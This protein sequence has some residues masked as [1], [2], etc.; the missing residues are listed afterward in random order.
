MR[1]STHFMLFLDTSEE[2]YG[3]YVVNQKQNPRH[4]FSSHSGCHTHQGPSAAQE[5]TTI[6]VGGSQNHEDF[7]KEQTK[8]VIK[9]EDNSH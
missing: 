3:S 7:Q 5:A 2:K 4:T 9:I 6:S 1:R 8:A